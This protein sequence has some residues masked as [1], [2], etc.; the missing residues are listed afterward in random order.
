M[1]KS[2][3]HLHKGNNPHCSLNDAAFLL[4]FG[5]E[6][7]VWNTYGTFKDFTVRKKTFWN[8]QHKS[9]RWSFLAG[10]E[11]QQVDRFNIWELIPSSVSPSA[12]IHLS[13]EEQLSYAM[14]ECL[15]CH[16]LHAKIFQIIVQCRPTPKAV[17][18]V[19]IE[20]HFRSLT[21]APISNLNCRIRVQ[22]PKI[23]QDLSL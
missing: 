4:T 10:S 11:M 23:S 3:R 5:Q 9:V 7:T 1:K 13:D 8:E 6:T 17:K 19:Q 15:L 21:A 2:P 14:L 12:L 22:R 16:P 20:A 18:R